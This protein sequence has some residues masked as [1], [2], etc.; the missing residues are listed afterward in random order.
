MKMKLKYFDSRALGRQSRRGR[1]PAV[2]GMQMITIAPHTGRIYVSV[3]VV[4]KF[5]LLT[6]RFGLAIDENSGNLFFYL[7]NE[8]G[9]PLIDHHHSF[10]V[11]CKNAVTEIL[12]DVVEDEKSNGSCFVFS[13]KSTE[14]EGR[15]FHEIKPQQ[16]AISKKK[17]KEILKA[18]S[19]GT[20]KGRVKTA[21]VLQAEKSLFKLT[22]PH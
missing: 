9:F 3:A 2:D 14:Q 13:G 8:H 1:K 5:S 10:Y 17:A 20:F 16:E 12:T 18:F 11:H 22:R 21:E 15:V 6:N 19:E 4:Q 7:D